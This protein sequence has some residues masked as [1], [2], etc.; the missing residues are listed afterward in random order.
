MKYLYN[1]NTGLT[2][3]RNKTKRYAT[4][5]LASVAVA[6]GIALPVA[7]AKGPIGEF[8]SN[9]PFGN[10]GEYISGEVYGNTSNPSGNG[11]GVLPSLAPGPWRCTNPAD[12]AGPTTAGG[13]MGEFI[14]PVASSGQASPDFANSKSPG[15]DFSSN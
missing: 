12:C 3:I 11:N 7:A 14:A 8:A 5:I 1:A 4:S 15:P 6:T 10:M 13:S 2:P 9:K